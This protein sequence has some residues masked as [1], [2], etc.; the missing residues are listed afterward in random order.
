MKTD[1][2]LIYEMTHLLI[3][4]LK[5]AKPYIGAI[6][7]HRLLITNAMDNGATE[8]KYLEMVSSGWDYIK[9]LYEGND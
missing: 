4:V 7:M 9:E 1:N 2:E 6:A 8:E 3:E 5:K